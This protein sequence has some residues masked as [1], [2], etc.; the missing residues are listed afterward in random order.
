MESLAPPEYLLPENPLFE[1]RYDPYLE[2]PWSAIQPEDI[3]GLTRAGRLVA[4][5][6]Q[7][8]LRA[9]PAG[10]QLP[11]RD[12]RFPLPFPGPFQ[13]VGEPDFDGLGGGGRVLVGKR[14]VNLT[15]P[16]VGSLTIDYR[17][18]PSHVGEKVQIVVGERTVERSLS[19][20]AGTLRIDDVGSSRTSVSVNIPGIFLARAEGSP[21]WQV[22]RVWP[23]ASGTE[24]R[25]DIPAGGGSISIAAYRTARS[26]RVSWNV[27]ELGPTP[28]SLTERPVRTQGLSA[29]RWGTR[30][31]A[32]A[33]SFAGTPL[34]PMKPIV[35]IRPPDAPAARLV[36]RADDAG[37][38]WMRAT[39]TWGTP[40]PEAPR[41][42]RQGAAE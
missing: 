29:E 3:E 20:A 32:T 5:D 19:A 37:M 14:A 17:V 4:F 1:V 35:V 39:A 10:N 16:S 22:R 33:L 30:P 36:L 41:H 26:G 23:L 18:S 15:P 7:V 42:I 28:A 13:L 27:E 9:L 11:E 40:E 24:A 8:R 34:E 21:A 12:A 25:I 6:A 31:D 38:V 2:Q